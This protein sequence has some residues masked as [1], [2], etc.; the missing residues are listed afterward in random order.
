MNR[1]AVTFLVSAAMAGCISVDRDAV[2][3][4]DASK[5]TSLPPSGAAQPV[6]RLPDGKSV[7]DVAA[8]VG[9]RAYA[10]INCTTAASL[11]RPLLGTPNVNGTADSSTT[12]AN[13]PIAPLP[14]A[15][16]LDDP[17]VNS[18]V[19]ATYTIAPP[20]SPMKSPS[21]ELNPPTSEVETTPTNPSILRLVNCKR[22]AFHYEIK[23]SGSSGV[24]ALE[25]WGTRDMHNWRKYDVIK[26][27]PQ[28]Y[29]VEVQDEGL[30]GFTMLAHGKGETEKVLPQPG[31]T[32]QV[33]VAVDLTKPAVQ[34]VGAELNILS[35]IP[36]LVIRWT[37][38]DANL[39]S[40]PI[41][42][43][44]AE[45]LEGPWTPIAANLENSGRYEWTMPSCVPANVFVRVQANDLAGNVGLAQ[46][47][48]P[49]PIPGRTAV[50]MCHAEPTTLELPHVVNAA[51]PS[52]VEAT[53]PK[54]EIIHPTVSILSVEGE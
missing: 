33:W 41:T 31:D 11:Q 46:T 27:T 4:G 9:Q 47:P 22:V 45:R 51:P 25:L 35:R 6:W 1:F 52:S 44:Y 26:R 21:P 43:A 14:Q 18:L 13:P 30:Y 38:K 19:Q 48:T 16:L 10:P 15:N 53:H 40:S 17:N 24:A 5:E 32:P 7:Q 42:L 36:S 20:I 39:G 23:D 12:M 37:A 28:S 54:T 2:T 49:L 8:D 3:S 50:T 34:L 29:V